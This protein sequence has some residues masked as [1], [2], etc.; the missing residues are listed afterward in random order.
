MNMDEFVKSMLPKDPVKAYEKDPLEEERYKFFEKVMNSIGDVNLVNGCKN[1]Q[2]CISKFMV[3]STKSYDEREVK[4]YN[5]EGNQLKYCAGNLKRYCD[6]YNKSN[7]KYHIIKDKKN[8]T[9][10]ELRNPIIV[11]E[12]DEKAS[13]VKSVIE[14]VKKNS[15]CKNSNTERDKVMT[16]RVT[17]ILSNLYIL[18]GDGYKFKVTSLVT[19]KIYSRDCKWSIQTKDVASAIKYI[20]S[21]NTFNFYVKHLGSNK[22]CS[23]ISK[24]QL[25]LPLES[26]NISWA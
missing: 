4:I 6:R 25:K 9:F 23:L 5:D 24:L 16:D 10:L 3:D 19:N 17:E 26:S 21:S 8:K 12:K 14:D 13:L 18:N 1:C 7:N 22:G 11:E 2:V 20:N 15:S